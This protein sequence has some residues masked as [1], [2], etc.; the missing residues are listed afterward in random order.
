M[1]GDLLDRFYSN[2]PCTPD[3]NSSARARM[4]NRLHLK[5]THQAYQNNDGNGYAKHQ[6]QYGSHS[7]L[8]QE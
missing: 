7:A 3:K 5:M 1:V 6:K 8:L 2:G 4:V